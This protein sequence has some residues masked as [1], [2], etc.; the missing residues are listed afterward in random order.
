MASVQW[1]ENE[2]EKHRNLDNALYMA[3]YMRNQ[4][5]FYGIKTPERRSIYKDIIR[6]AKKAESI[7]W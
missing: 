1:V 3:K 5:D 7:D 6:E 4:F 2:F